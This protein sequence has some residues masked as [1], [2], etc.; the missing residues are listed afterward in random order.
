[1]NTQSP[2]APRRLSSSPAKSGVSRRE[3]AKWA[4]VAGSSLAAPRAAGQNNVRWFSGLSQ[5]ADCT[6]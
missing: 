4:T 5:E 3:V 1:M 2:K 6:A